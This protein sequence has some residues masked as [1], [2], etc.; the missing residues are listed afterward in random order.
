MDDDD[1]PQPAPSGGYVPGDTPF[2]PA[3]KRPWVQR[4][5]PVAEHVPGYRGGTLGHDA[6]AGITVA[7]LAL[8][9][10]MAYGE[11]A[12][13]SPV[14]GLYTLLLPAVAY[15]FFGSSR[16]VIVGPEGAIAAM[17]GAAL[18]PMTPD[19]EQRASLAALLALLVGA[20]YLLALLARLGWIAD[21]L[22]R[23]VLIGYLNG[24]AVV[25]IIGQLGKLLGLNIGAETPPGQLV[26]VIA[27][28]DQVSWP[29]VLVGGV[30]LALLLVARW[31]APK[32]PAALI[33]VVLAIITSAA[34]GLA[35]YGVA[36]VGDIPAGLPGIELPDLR[37]R[38]IL[39]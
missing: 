29:T 10:A 18:I 2:L 15:A 20:A 28:I 24:V 26:E 30:C 7:A 36:V 37:L 35:G 39:D 1:R 23:P 38:A 11:L 25:M 27:E 12:G 3:A 16:Q 17:V 5:V 19:P 8:P 34:L 21:Y 9:A 33:V 14:I 22:S 13:L 32:T 6:L 4:I 31:L